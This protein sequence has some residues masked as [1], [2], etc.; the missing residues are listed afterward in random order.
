MQT[1]TVGRNGRG[2]RGRWRE[3]GR[4]HATRTYAKKGEARAALNAEL[5]RIRLGTAYR[6]PITLAQLADRFLAQYIAAPQ[7]IQYA[8]RRLKRPLAAS[9][10]LR[11]SR[12]RRWNASLRSAVAGGRW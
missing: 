5:D 4:L 1:G 3:D 10:S 12:G 8:R 2:W 6:V 7:T 11:L 9:G